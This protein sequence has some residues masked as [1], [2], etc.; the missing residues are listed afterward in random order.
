MAQAQPRGL[1]G[2]LTGP[3]AGEPVDIAL[4]HIRNHALPAGQPGTP[5]AC[6]VTGCNT[7]PHNRVTH[8]YMR[9]VI[10]GLEVYGA[11]LSIHVGRHGEVLSMKSRFL[12]L[13][14]PASAKAARRVTPREAVAAAAGHLGLGLTGDLL[15]LESRGGIQAETVLSGGGI[16]RH[17]IPVKKMWQPGEDGI[18]HLVWNFHIRTNDGR[19]WWNV[20]VDA[21]SGEIRYL[22]DWVWNAAYRA[23][24]LPLESPAEG[25]TT[26]HA[27]AHDPL[28]SPFAWHDT[29]GIPGSEHTDTRGNNV[30]AQ[31]DIVADNV[32][33]FRPS[34]GVGLT[35]DFPL[36]LSLDPAQNA[37]A[38]VANLFY[39]NNVLHDIHYRYG[40]T[41]SAGNFQMN[42]YG[43][44]GAGGD[45]LQA[46]AQ[47]GSDFN[48][49][50]MFS[51]PDG[52]SPRMQMFV[53]LQGGENLTVQSP[54]AIAG[55]YFVGVAA[56]GPRLTSGGI[57]GTVV[58]ALDPPDPPLNSATDACSPM[59]NGLALAGNIALI[60]RGE[61]FFVEKVK[62]AQDAGAIAVLVVNHEGDAI[63]T[64]GG[65]D[66]T[67]TIPSLFLGQFDGD[68][69]K[70]ELAN[71]V[72]VHM[73]S[74]TALDSSLDN[75]IIIHEYGHGVSTRLTGG[76][77]N[78]G[79]L[80]LPQSGGMG[81][82]WSDWWSLAL[83]ATSNDT[84]VTARGVGTYV[85]RDVPGGPGIRR[86]P[87]STD[88]AINPLTYGDIFGLFDEHDIGEVWCVAL[89]DMYWNLVEKFGFD[90]DFYLGS[91]GNN[92]ALQLVMDGLKLQPCNPTFLEA[93]DAILMADLVNNAGDNTCLLWQAFAGRGMGA[94]ALDGGSALSTSV[95][96][97]FS[98]PAACIPAAIS[99]VTAGVD[100]VSITWQAASGAVYGIEQNADLV[101]GS[102][103]P[104]AGPI[105]ANT[106][107]AGATI[108]NPVPMQNFLRVV[109][110]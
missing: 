8:V 57:T 77:A 15:V 108:T 33:D 95:T 82:G 28:A 60:D 27:D 75:G 19:H 38:S 34:G 26:L 97:D 11:D 30:S 71:G 92:L 78:S 100:N 65:D 2:F 29:N 17:E 43:K 45:P 67:I 24:R 96:E 63:V 79:C 109:N 32:A 16:S 98:V 20:N 64:M 94:N 12:P 21:Q 81:E 54:P 58:Q 110:Q 37:P 10:G 6:V 14:P 105:T 42:N 35:F 101:S 61:C 44:G 85:V 4:D 53:W 88:T 69:L 9:Q 91:G 70:A 49:A 36:N 103:I 104:V 46:D 87:Y 18:L 40:F 13:L 66:P 59:T 55:D 62:R 23:F 102:W 80:S 41:E 93:R 47:D 48:N 84:P 68:A 90:P 56:F 99:A 25:S 83:T 52:F 22:D 51:P 39:V 74:S 3:S 31:L 1:A 86:F 107:T 76:P 5:P 50:E 72:V 89:W 106:T 73:T 7:S